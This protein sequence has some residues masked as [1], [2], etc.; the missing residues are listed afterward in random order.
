MIIKKHA[1]IIVIGGGIVGS[2][3]LFQLAEAGYTNSVLLEKSKF[4]SGSTNASGGFLR[5][6]HNDF[7]HT[8]M[9]F[10]G[11]SE[12]NR[13]KNNCDFQKT[14]M[15]YVINAQDKPKYDHQIEWLKNNDVSID[16]LPLSEYETWK[17]IV[18]FKDTDSIVFE[19]EAGYLD[20]VSCTNDWINKAVKKGAEAHEGIDV[21]KILFS[22]NEIKGVRTSFGDIYC[23]ILIIAAGAWTSRLVRPLGI[24]LGIYSKAIQINFFE[25]QKQSLH[26]I[27]IDENSDIYLRP[28]AGG[29]SILMGQPTSEFEVNLEQDMS[30]NYEDTLQLIEKHNPQYNWLNIN[31]LFGGRRS[32]DAFTH[33]SKGILKKEDTI[34]GLI[35]ASGWSGGGVKLS[36]S[37]GKKVTDLVESL[38]KERT[39]HESFH[40][41]RM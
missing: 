41:G 38:K 30:L 27:I 3:I 31:N 16:Y 13:I 37:I 26:P 8:K 25:N 7:E 6:L 34:D 12:F 23:N 35:V 28:H 15:V 9:A 1:D 24:D 21:Q 4:A 36:P 39:I 33:D 22:E 29:N 17:N 11:L 14:G 18:Q 10:E 2:S 32:F 40:Y 19:K 5:I 20:P